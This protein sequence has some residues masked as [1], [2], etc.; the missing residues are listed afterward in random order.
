V[1]IV[2]EGVVPPTR[3]PNPSDPNTGGGGGGV[4]AVIYR[5]GVASSPPFVE[6]WAE[7]QSVIAESDGDCIVYTDDSVVSPALVPA[8]SGV[9]DCLGRVEFRAY[10]V[11]F[12]N[13]ST[14]Q[15]EDGAT[16]KS[17]FRIVGSMEILGDTQGAVPAFDFD[18]TPNVVGTPAPGIILQEGGFVGNTPTCTAPCIVVPA[19]QTLVLTFD[20]RAGIYLPATATPFFIHLAA[21]SSNLSLLGLNAEFVSFGSASGNVADGAGGVVYQFDSNTANVIVSPVPPVFTVGVLSSEQLDDWYVPSRVADWSGVAP[22][23]VAN[24]LDRIAAK[25]TPIP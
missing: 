1:P 17:I 18:Y 12:V 25:I 9:T 22:S 5:P 6:T 11:D 8:S 14:L 2:E 15:I 21:A 20:T 10:R 7:V 24:A 19:L 3:S 4:A 23:S 16:L 13:Y